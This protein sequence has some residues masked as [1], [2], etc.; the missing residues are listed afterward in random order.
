Q[1]VALVVGEHDALLGG[2]EADRLRSAAAENSDRPAGALAV[3][4]PTVLNADMPLDEA[5]D[6]LAGSERSWLPVAEEGSKRPIGVVDARALVRSYREAA[7]ASSARGGNQP[8][9]I[10]VLITDISPAAGRTL[11][12]LGFPPGA[13]VVNILRGD[14]VLVPNG[15]ST[16]SAGDHVVVALES[17]NLRPQV[18]AILDP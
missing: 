2:I 1:R 5:F 9:T 11:A 14:A 13:R 16:L 18:D 12:E 17:R 6:A 4:A 15:Q 7:S 8:E 10:T 3:P